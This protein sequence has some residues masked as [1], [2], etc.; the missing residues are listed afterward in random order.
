MTTSQPSPQPGVAFLKYP[1]LPKEIRLM[2][3]EE[4][5]EEAI[6]AAPQ[7]YPQEDASWAVHVVKKL[8]PLAPL[9]GVNLEWNRV[10]EMRLFKSITIAASELADFA[11]YCSKRH[12]RLNTIRL[13]IKHEEID[14]G[15][16]PEY[17]VGNAVS[18]LLNTMHLWDPQDRERHSLVEVQIDIWDIMNASA[19]FQISH[20]F[21]MLPQVPLIEALYEVSKPE[22]DPLLHPWSSLALYRALPNVRRAGL[23]LRRV[24]HEHL[25]PAQNVHISLAQARNHIFFLGATHPNLTHLEL[26]PDLQRFNS[27]NI[28]RLWA[29]GSNCLAA[30]PPSWHN[31]LVRLELKQIKEL[32]GFL[33]EAG[34]MVWPNL[35]TLV[36]LGD[37]R[38]INEVT[39]TTVVRGL[40][41]LMSKTPKL[42]TV[43]VE[44]VDFAWNWDYESFRIQMCLGEM[45]EGVE[46]SSGPSC[47]FKP[48]SYSF[49]PTQDLGTVVVS[50]T[51]VLGEVA[52]ELQRT[53]QI[54]QRKDLAVFSH[55]LN[56]SI[57]G[58]G[59]CRQW[60]AEKSSW[61]VVFENEADEIIY[62]MG[63]YLDL[64]EP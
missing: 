59:P 2:V 18:Q 36:L 50:G 7:E 63:Q 43:L 53:V 42:T 33:A 39:C 52:T 25:S 49:V 54:N 32:P 22:G 26:L 15:V 57:W 31:T 6:R 29:P 14:V 11:E 44:M 38:V 46:A 45:A 64:T 12:G 55:Y 4:A 58:R 3:I 56:Q 5:V 9:S 41:A 19:D 62:Q 37:L 34:R 21:G 47:S 28:S 35:K 24:N 23:N 40:I 10:I 51:K 61:D 8:N 17:F 20:G 16:R 48:C 60:D 27:N 30:F 1:D 13:A